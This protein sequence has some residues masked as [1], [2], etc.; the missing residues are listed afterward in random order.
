ML[1]HLIGLEVV[2]KHAYNLRNIYYYISPYSYISEK[3][4]RCAVDTFGADHVVFGSDTPFDK[5]SLRKVTER[6]RNMDLSDSQ[7]EQILGT[8][9]AMLLKL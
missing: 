4:I 7:K 3:R 1:L 9:I 8:N 6:V 5:D 2:A